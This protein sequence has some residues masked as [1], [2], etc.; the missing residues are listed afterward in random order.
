MS[1]SGPSGW[2]P[3]PG[4]FIL[5][6]Q[7][8]TTLTGTGGGARLGGSVLRWVHL[9]PIRSHLGRFL[10]SGGGRL[11]LRHSRSRLT[12]ARSSGYSRLS[13][14]PA[15]PTDT[16]SCQQ[17]LCSG[18]RQHVHGLEWRHRRWWVTQV[19][20]PRCWPWSR[21]KRPWPRSSLWVVSTRSM[22]G[23]EPGEG[24]RST[25][26][27]GRFRSS[28]GSIAPGS[29]PPV[30][31]AHQLCLPV[32]SSLPPQEAISCQRRHPA[33]GWP[34]GSNYCPAGQL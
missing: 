20:Y 5:P 9:L 30:S 26:T 24:W 32:G 33:H 17:V 12:E 3:T 19:S 11:L 6:G 15:T 14:C 34:I 1:V 13:L 31:P 22:L 4:T 7:L 28:V 25:N 18:C 23:Q 27:F 16:G 8:L 29:V 2:G 10:P 21:W